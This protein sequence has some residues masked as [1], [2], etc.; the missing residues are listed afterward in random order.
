M[1][2]ALRRLMR[3]PDDTVAVF[4]IMRTLNRPSTRAGYLRL[5][6]RPDGARLAYERTELAARLMDD[7]WLDGFAPGTLGAAY[8]G[9]VRREG[10]S[11]EGLATV[12]RQGLAAHEIDVP[13]PIAWYGRRIRDTHDLW[14]MLTGYG[15]DPLGEACLV[16]FSFSQTRGR[17]WLLIALGA[18]AKGGPRAG[19]ARRDRRGLRAGAPR[20]VAAGLRRRGADGDADRRRARDAADRAATRLSRGGERASRLTARQSETRT[21]TLPIASRAASRAIARPPSSSVKTWSIRGRMRPS[22]HQAISCS[23]CARWRAGLARDEAA[24]EHAA[25]VAALE[26]RQIERQPGDAGGKADDQIAA[27]PGDRAQR[28][29]GIVAADRIVRSHARRHDRPR[30]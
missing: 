19:R 14:H 16:A 27:L 5:I 18:L 29:L 13:D 22:P 2:G 28:R 4:E 9:F 1:F 6:A 25:H 12:S 3:D 23:T 11:A 10:L 26:Q 24:P 8:R 21:T 30:P 7:A 15:R 17:G 20:Q